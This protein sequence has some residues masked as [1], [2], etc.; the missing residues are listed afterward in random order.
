MN[1]LSNLQRKLLKYIVKNPNVLFDQ[2]K[3]HFRISHDDLLD[4]LTILRN[5]GYL[6]QD[7][8]FR[9][10]VYPTTNGKNYFEF[11]TKNSFEIVIKSVVCPIIVSFITTLITLWLKGS[12]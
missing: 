3:K 5:L 8:N 4:N 12:L 9:G 6:E 1:T 2:I 11:E 10:F 7:C